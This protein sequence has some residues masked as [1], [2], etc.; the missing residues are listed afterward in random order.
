MCRRN[1]S[2]FTA[3]MDVPSLSPFCTVSF[4]SRGERGIRTPEMVLA[5]YTLSKRAPSAT[6]PPLLVWKEVHY[7]MLCKAIISLYFDKT[8]QYLEKFQ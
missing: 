3:G 5:I 8:I 6:R 1:T 2:V 4:L 7:K